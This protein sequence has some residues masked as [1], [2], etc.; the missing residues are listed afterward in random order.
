LEQLEERRLSRT[1]ASYNSYLLASLYAE[2]Q[3]SESRLQLLRVSH[4]NLSELYRTS[5]ALFFIAKAWLLLRFEYHILEEPLDVDHVDLYSGC[6]SY[7]C[8]EVP[9]YLNSE[10]EPNG[11]HRQLLRSSDIDNE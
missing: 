7:C 3:V 1:S 5:E 9:R 2:G 11:H 10:L 4:F 8:I 6:P